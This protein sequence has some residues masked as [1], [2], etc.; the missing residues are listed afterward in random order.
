MADLD[1]LKDTIERSSDLWQ[2]GQHQEALKFLDDCLASASQEKRDD[3]ITIL[4]M[5]A[6]VI[7]ESMGDLGLVRR[8]C[9]QVLAYDPQNALALF[10]LADVLFSTASTRVG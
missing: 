2:S 1:S 3:W 5:H 10:R 7:A 4:G 8:Y 6:S 9:E